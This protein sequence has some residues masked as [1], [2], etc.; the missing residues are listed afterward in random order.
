MFWDKLCYWWLT[1]HQYLLSIS[2]SDSKT[3]T[4][5]TFWS[6][7]KCMPKLMIF[8]WHCNDKIIRWNL[9]AFRLRHENG[10][11]L[12]YPLS[13]HGILLWIKASQMSKHQHST[14]GFLTH[15]QRQEASSSG[16]GGGEFTHEA[17]PARCASHYKRSCC[18]FLGSY[19]L[20]FYTPK[21]A[22]CQGRA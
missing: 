17:T 9:D 3:T 18:I 11:T 2:L 7:L 22:W 21:V 4:N 13:I 19:K 5:D 1:G 8:A 12:T 6:M 14:R 15:A 16:R 20:S 10:L